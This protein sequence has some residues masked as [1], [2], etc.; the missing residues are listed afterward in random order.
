MKAQEAMGWIEDL[1][2]LNKRILDAETKLIAQDA[3]IVEM[4]EAGEDTA[5]AME[6]HRAYRNDL[7]RIRRLRNAMLNDIADDL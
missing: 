4:I 1:L 6:L 2:H 7:Q 3:V 5:G